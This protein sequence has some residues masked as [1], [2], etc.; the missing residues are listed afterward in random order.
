MGNDYMGEKMMVYNNNL[1]MPFKAKTIIM[2]NKVLFFAAML[3]T[4]VFFASCN[5]QEEEPIHEQEQ[6]N[7]DLAL[8]DAY[9]T[10]SLFLENGK[11]KVY[12][13]VY[14]SID[15]Y[16]KP[17]MLSGTISM[18]EAVSGKA[19][20]KGFILYNHPTIYRADQCPSK[21]ELSMQSLAKEMDLITVS[22]DYYGFGITEHHH[23]AYCIS[24]CNGRASIDA[25]IA[26]KGLLSQM[27]F[28]WG[29]KIFNVGYSQGGQTAVA[30]MRLAAEQYRDL[31]ITYTFAGAGSYDLPETYHQ[32]VDATIA[33]MPSTVVSVLLSYNEFKG[34][35]FSNGDMFLEP[36]AS[37]INDWFLS[38]SYT[39]Q[40]IDAMVGSLAIADYL[41]PVLLDTNSSRAGELFAALD[42]DNLCHG[43][44]PRGDE[45]V[46]LFHSNQ[47]IT[48]PVANTQNL[49]DFLTGNGVTD[50][51][52][53]LQDVAATTANPA[54]ENA[55]RNFAILV[56]QRIMSVIDD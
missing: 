32:F 17:I 9:I 31:N 8:G 36:V 56:I 24:L 2:R 44:T 40:E 46:M 23:Q 29:D 48:V 39:R 5:K 14:P 3:L 43:W 19:S 51:D 52:L 13:Y 35:E 54:H 38:K 26:A 10:D 4:I 45:H 12:N 16:G 41:S 15:P 37:H 11:L 25:F 53:Q 1:Q 28:S 22:A 47:D 20:A 55:A 21:G 49:Y 7:L 6:P 50:I 33:G 18:G 30:V 42:Q 27:G 34:L